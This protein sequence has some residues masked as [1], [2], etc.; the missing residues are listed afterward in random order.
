MVLLMSSNRNH[1]SQGSAGHGSWR[2]LLL[3]HLPLESETGAFILINVLDYLV[4]YFLLMQ[5]GRGVRFVESNPV[6]QY[7]IDSW[8]PGKGMLGFKMAVV[9]FVCV[10]SQVIALKREDYGRW[11]LMLGCLATGFVVVYSLTLY[12]RHA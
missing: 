6:A 5:P 12:L 11:V 10:L 8:G 1:M 2:R 9:A 7:F 3:G 4:T